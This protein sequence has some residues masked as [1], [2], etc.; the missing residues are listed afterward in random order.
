MSTNINTAKTQASGIA[1][2]I[3]GHSSAVQTLGNIGTDPHPERL[4]AVGLAHAGNSIQAL[5][6]AVEAL[7]SDVVALR[8]EL[9]RRR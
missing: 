2:A 1:G 3:K 6:K 7:E 4:L 5:I 9:Q 8:A